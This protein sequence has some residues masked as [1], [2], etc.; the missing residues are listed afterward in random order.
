MTTPD[1]ALLA[2]VDAA[3]EWSAWVG[4]V[5]AGSPESR[6]LQAIRDVVMDAPDG[7]D[8]AGEVVREC[9]CRLR[10]RLVGDGCD[11]CNPELAA[12]YARRK[13]ATDGD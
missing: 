2:L 5:H 12:E 3:R 6:L 4:F 8:G 10:T 11:V 1:P 9:Q 13:E 7:A